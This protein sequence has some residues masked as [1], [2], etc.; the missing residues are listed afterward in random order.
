MS[1]PSPAIQQHTPVIQQYLG[2][3]QQHPEKLLFFRMGD[4]YELFFDDARKAARLLDITL[5][6]RGQSADEPI[7]MA[8]VPYHAVENYL[9]R[10]IRLGESV[11]I[12]EQIGDPATSKGPVERR[13][14]RI[15][16]PGTVTD[17]AL[18]EQNQDCCLLALHSNKYGIGLASL[19]LG[20]GRFRVMQLANPD[21]LPAELKRISP[22]EILIS[23]NADPT[24]YSQASCRVTT[25]PEWYFD[26]KQASELLVRQYHLQSLTGMDIDGMVYA[27]S[28]AGAALHYARETQCQDILH[29]Q[30]VVVE[31]SEDGITLDSISRRNLEL[32]QDLSGR[33]QNSLLN[34]IDTTTTAMGGRLLRRWVVQPLRD[35]K[36]LHLRHDAVACLLENRIY[37]DLRDQLRLI[38]D[39]ERIV[40]RAALGTARPRDLVQLR[41]TLA[42][43]PA[44]HDFLVHLS[45]M[46]L[47]ELDQQIDLLPELKRWLDLALVDQPPVTLRDGG[48]IADG[49]DPQLDELRQLSTDVSNWL[50]DLEQ[51]EKLRT[52]L[53]NLKVGY[54]RV[55]GYYIEISRL[56]SD[57]VPVEYH[58]RQTL[59]ATERFI[60][61]E[62]KQFEEKVLGAREQALARE[63]LLYETILERIRTHLV[64][65][66]TTASAL[67]E[68]DVLAC[69]A[70]RADQLGYCRPE[71]SETPGI[72]I[73]QGRHPVVEQ[74]QE[75]PFIGNDLEMNDRRRML[76]ITGPN[77]GGKST[78]MRQTALIVILAHIG[79]FVPAASATIGPIDRIFTRI[80]AS[81]DLASGQSTFM[82]EMVETA[83]ILNNAS[84]HSLVLM[85]EIGRGTSTYDGLALAWACAGYLAH[86]VKAYTLFATHY[87]ELTALADLLDATINLHFDA[88]EHGETIV[89]M[90]SVKAGPASRSYGLQVAQLAGIPKSVI[91]NARQ[92]LDT[93]ET[94][95]S[96]PAEPAVTPGPAYREHPLV[97]AMKN[98]NPDLITPQQALEI[99]YNLKKL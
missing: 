18:L 97:V 95:H 73:K 6:R 45:S 10:L 94:G 27:I 90:H 88:V 66:Q 92:R 8:G 69:F 87:F 55:H 54:N 53:S 93:M 14:T 25:R 57:S 23:E 79:S 70:E 36:I 30:P 81:D 22:A 56:H 31:H 13:I 41:N 26:Y 20:S 3:K 83:N 5:T 49:F 47:R 4:F 28:A 67:A 91:V 85:D 32:V 15:V 98:I 78:Y 71:F 9:A 80:G 16:T 39:I 68:L 12:C 59:K 17:E 75:A 72:V 46:H 7:P 21:M 60:T 38:S 65:I 34:V 51:K 84:E 40:T 43:L 76:I 62:L 42:A 64:S 89:F 33:K 35:Q 24:L 50:L 77:M 74:I 96:G 82:V 99:L 61:D 63:K 19:D 48:V 2:F 37:N 58:R 29:L 1:I 44:I 86:K 11:V 52:G